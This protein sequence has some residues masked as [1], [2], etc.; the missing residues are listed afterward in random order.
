[1][2]L[3]AGADPNVASEEMYENGNRFVRC[4]TALIS[5][6][7]STDHYGA[8][9]EIVDLLIAG[10]AD[11]N[12]TCRNGENALLGAISNGQTIGV[13]KLL[14]AGAD[15]KGEKGGTALAQAKKLLQFEY[16][17]RQMEEIIKLLEAAGAGSSR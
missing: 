15:V 12:F 11:V 17:K 7:Q 16:I 1:L 2:L 9:N 10:K 4:E 3:E 8:E 6:A 14:A 5:A 13:K